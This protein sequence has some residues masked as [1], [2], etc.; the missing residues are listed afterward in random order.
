MYYNGA[1]GD[2]APTARPG[3]SDNWEKAERYGRELGI[4]VWKLWQSIRPEIEP[5]FA[6]HVEQIQLPKRTW[7]PDF[8]KTGGAEYG[9]NDS[10]IRAVIEGMSPE[11]THSISLR[12]GEL[13]IAGVPGELVAVLG[14][15]VKARIRR[16]LGVRHAVIG[17]L[18][19]EWISYMLTPEEYRKGDYE[20]SISFYGERL[21]PVIVDAVTRGAGRLANTR[22]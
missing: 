20:A 9:L 12:L 1:Q 7:H 16:S 11:T 22:H 3:A 14:D 18:A 6:C 19:D 15:D 21:G 13:V 8:L 2:Q 5:A 10:N 4:Q 17:G